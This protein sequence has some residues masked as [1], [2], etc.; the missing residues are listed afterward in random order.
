M[1]VVKINV[2]T[3]VGLLFVSNLRSFIL[4]QRAFSFSLMSALNVENFSAAIANYSACGNITLKGCYNLMSREPDLAF[5]HP[6]I[7]SATH[8][9]ILVVWLEPVQSVKPIYQNNRTLG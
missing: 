8:P 6:S 4:L 3:I 2:S 1:V 9:S 7:H 5:D